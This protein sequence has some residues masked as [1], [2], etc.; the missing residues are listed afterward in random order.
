MSRQQAAVILIVAGLLAGMAAPLSAAPA[1]ALPAATASKAPAAS[2]S[3]TPAAPAAD[4]VK[5]PPITPL[6]TEKA[7]QVFQSLYGEDLRRTIATPSS[8]DDLTLAARLLADAKATDVPPALLV[9]L[10]ANACQ[11]G[12]CDPRGY[13]TSLEAA[14]LLAA[15]VPEKADTCTDTVLLIRQRQYETSRGEE[16]FRAGETFVEQLLAVA[17]SRASAADYAEANRRARQALV[18]ARTIR[19]PSAE[20]IDGQIKRYVEMLQI[21]AKAGQLKTALEADPTNRDVRQQLI[22][23]WVVELDHPAEAAALLDDASSPAFRKYAPA[24]AKP[25]DAAPQLASLELGDWYRDL[26]PT[27]TTTTGKAAML[28]R[29]AAYYRRFLDLDKGQDFD[30]PKAEL[31]LK[32]AEAEL[33]ALGPLGGN[34]WTDLLRMIDPTRD[35][36]SG[37]SQRTDAGLA[38]A[39]TAKSSFGKVQILA[40][41]TGSYE[42][43][44]RFARTQGGSDVGFIL[45][46]GGTSVFLNFGGFTNSLSGLEDIGGQRLNNLDTAIKAGLV[47]GHLYTLNV[48]VT[49]SPAAASAVGTATSTVGPQATLVITVDGKPLTKWAGPAALLSL[50]KIWAVPTAH[51]FGL[52]TYAST[53]LYQSLRVRMLSG[54]LE[55]PKPAPK[56]TSP[57]P[58]KTA[59]P[60]TPTSSHATK[61]PGW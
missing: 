21:V 33:D 36:V 7:A 32:K 57:P 12:A 46:V 13:D 14:A 5:M 8:A 41:P 40:I 29:E 31:A 52:A 48:R 10:C 58:T 22:R 61:S 34:R 55:T 50:E 28:T 47:T 42:L 25:V 30:R 43:E 45:P 53:G 2:A 49:V 4:I 18:I 56:P 17:A 1:L 26:V 15:K 20:D 3:A 54:R 37:V 16:R 35:T 39:S 9:L 6:D 44:A 23:L 38:I 59:A 19:S 27:A 51:G 11:L 60:P 24:A